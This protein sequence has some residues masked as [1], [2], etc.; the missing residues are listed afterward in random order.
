[1]T[2]APR[3]VGRQAMT[4]PLPTAFCHGATLLPVPDGSLLGAWFGGTA[5]GLPDSG[6]YV[7]RL[8]AGA[9]AW[10]PPALVAPADGRPCG[11]PVLFA[12][13]PG[14]LW[15]AYFR[16]WGAWCTGGKPCARVSF[17]G[18]QTWSDEM[19]LLDRAGV[20]TKNKPLR[21]GTTLLLPVYDE[22]RWQVGLAR[23][24]V[25]RHGTAWVFDDLAIGAGTG[26]AMI[27]G[28]LVLGRPGRL[29]M[30]MRTRAGRIWA[31]ESADGGYTWSAPHPTELPNPNAGI[32]M[33]RLP[34]GRLWLAYNHTDR[35][36]DPMQW[37]LRSPLCL[38]ESVNGGATWT[39]LLVLEEGPGEYS[40]PAVVVDGAGRVHVA[41]TAL[42]REIR[43]VVLEP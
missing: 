38:A 1:M 13:A 36:R 10:S 34:D 2:T 28:T 14:V 35:G 33:A 31:T 43:H 32:D 30:L 19:L 21:L 7:A 26:V 12:G 29:L 3:V 15:L 41:Y 5:E 6:I 25:A 9:S 37:E 11:N 17:D 23:L 24:D 27:Q 16:V 40:Y 8:E 42:R 18:G 4:N 22:V 39:P 20:L